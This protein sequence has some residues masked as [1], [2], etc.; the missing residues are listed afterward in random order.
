MFQVDNFATWYKSTKLSAAL[1]RSCGAQRKESSHTSWGHTHTPCQPFQQSSAGICE[2]QQLLA[3]RLSGPELVPRGG[4]LPAGFYSTRGPGLKEGLQR[5][6][7]TGM[8]VYAFVFKMLYV[9]AIM[10]WP[11]GYLD[12]LGPQ[13]AE[14]YHYSCHS[15]LQASG[16]TGATKKSVQQPRGETVMGKKHNVKWHLDVLTSKQWPCINVKTHI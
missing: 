8:D 9:L 2:A 1:M 11:S 14:Q 3:A 13:T 10:R 5:F 7:P 4:T 6:G 12:P 16:T 15:Y